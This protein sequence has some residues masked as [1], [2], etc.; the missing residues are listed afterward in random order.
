MKITAGVSAILL[1]L[2]LGLAG[3]GSDHDMDDESGDSMENS[4]DAMMNRADD[5]GH[6]GD[7]DDM[8]SQDAAPEGS[9]PAEGQ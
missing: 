1:A 4:S 5:T 9:A 3:C 2:G 7:S 6:A 8:M